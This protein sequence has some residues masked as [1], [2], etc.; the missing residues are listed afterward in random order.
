MKKFQLAFVLEIS[1]DNYDEAVE[2]AQLIES[3]LT[4]GVDDND[5]DAKLQLVLEYDEDNN[6]QRVLYLPP[7]DG[8]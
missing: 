1:A 2:E 8:E 4:L 3:I 6:G 5:T 7:A